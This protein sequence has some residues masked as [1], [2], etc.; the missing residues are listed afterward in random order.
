MASSNLSPG[1]GFTETD[2]TNIVGSSGTSGGAFAGDFAWGPV[3]QIATV[4]SPLELEKTYHKPDDKNYTS[5][6]SA[7]NFLAYTGDLKIVRAADEDAI[8]SS[9]DG[10]GFLVKNS[11]HFEVVKTAPTTVQFAAKYPG[12]L[13]DSIA[14]HMAD[15]STFAGWQYAYLFDTAPGSS[16]WAE[17]LGAANDELHIVIVDKQGKFSGVVGSVLETFS[18][19]SK[20]SDSKDA[21]NGPNFYINVLNRTSKYVWALAL[22][23]GADLSAPSTGKVASVTVGAGGTGYT[24]APT[25]TFS[26]PATG[27]VRA[28]GTATVTAGAVTG[29]TITNAGSGYVTAP[30]ITFAGAGTGATATAVVG[31]VTD[32]AEWGTPGVVAGE[33]QTFKRLVAVKAAP[34]TGGKDSTAITAGDLTRAYD[35]FSNQEEVD[36]SLIFTG[37]AGGETEHNVTVQSAIDNLAE[38]RRDCVVFYSPQLSDVLNKTQSD[39]VNAVVS[40]RNLVGRASS[41]AVMDSGWKLQYDV[42]ND[43]YRWIPLNADL[44]GLCAQVD[45]T[46]DPWVSPGG[47]TRGR[48]KNVVSLAFNPN[49]TSR[50]AIYK[51]GINPVV[52]FNTD[53]TV[54]Y[55]DKTL[56]GKNSAF[57][58][59]GTRRLFISLEKDIST[60]A[61]YY[62]FETNNDFTR[63]NFVNM[64][65][66]KLEQVRGRGG[67]ED[68]RVV[69][70]TSNN[71]AEVIMNRQFVGSIFIKPVY[72]INWVQ[73]N[74][75]AVRQDV[76]FDEVVGGT[77]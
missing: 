26:L 48:L 55:G 17:S 19:L 16:Q 67:I 31:T 40:T 49:K 18:Y 68:F 9:D 27:G 20:A 71:T 5:W 38:S 24:A 6:F 14:V 47:Y 74:F 35:L 75:V 11:N 64:V 51:V 76:S 65:S 7:F 46:N 52:T 8:N 58:Q 45:S 22:P 4:S 72:S 30:T 13:G 57:G 28:T 37:D 69:C 43:K 77:F 21:N 53:G 23:T 3:E 56:L 29:V 63:N 34:L 66:P 50:D 44:A 10:N 33:A 36:V 73:L 60:A 59:I 54:L 1:V 41:Y 12:A 61:K 32:A 70:D 39:A 62:L 15:A 25:V 42:Y 2:L